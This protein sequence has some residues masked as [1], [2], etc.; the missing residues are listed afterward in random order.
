MGWSRNVFRGTPKM[1][2]NDP[3]AQKICVDGI[4]RGDDLKLSLEERN[5]FYMPLHHSEDITLLKKGLELAPVVGYSESYCRKR[6]ADMQRFGRIPSRN[7]DRGWAS[8]P[9]EKAAGY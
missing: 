3:L 6:I 4:A 8:T 1:F 5:M 7:R 2:E 9:A